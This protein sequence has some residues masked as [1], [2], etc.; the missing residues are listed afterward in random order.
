MGI[1]GSWPCSTARATSSSSA[2]GRTAQY[3]RGCSQSP[4]CSGRY[5]RS[6]SLPGT[7]WLHQESA[8]RPVSSRSPATDSSGASGSAPPERSSSS[9][10]QPS[11]VSA[12]QAVRSNHRTRRVV[13]PSTIGSTARSR[14]FEQ[15]CH[16][17]CR[18]T[19][20]TV[21]AGVGSRG[22]A[23]AHRVPSNASQ[24]TAASASSS[25]ASSPLRRPPA[26]GP[27]AVEYY[28][29]T[30]TSSA[31]A[32]SALARPGKYDDLPLRVVMYGWL[33]LS[34]ARTNSQGEG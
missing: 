23:R 16:S 30:L 15:S 19:V 28:Q 2:S 13:W 20:T 1:Q 7:A 31:D 21:V 9:A 6:T 12:V 34:S 17:R 5:D 4:P 27:S 10:P 8:L 33:P 22:P 32:V 29:P 14:T 26:P 18:S 25:P 11:R 24:L 3:E